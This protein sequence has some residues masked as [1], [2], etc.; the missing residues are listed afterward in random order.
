MS[1]VK[2]TYATGD[3]LVVCRKTHLLKYLCWKYQDIKDDIRLVLGSWQSMAF[4]SVL[5][6]DLR[7][8]LSTSLGLVLRICSD[9]VLNSSM[10]HN[11]RLS[12]TRSSRA[13]IASVKIPTDFEICAS[14]LNSYRALVRG[15]IILKFNLNSHYQ[16]TILIL[17]LI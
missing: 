11:S 16:K 7:E 5:H 12:C 3:H 6:A 2:N 10:W 13:P 1:C 14:I 8:V 9:K 15:P 17:V 4:V